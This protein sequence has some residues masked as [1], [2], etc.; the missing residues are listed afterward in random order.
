M[1][2]AEEGIHQFLISASSTKNSCTPAWIDMPLVS[3]TQADG[4]NTQDSRLQV[5]L[6]ELL[7]RI[8]HLFPV[9]SKMEWTLETD[10]SCESLTWMVLP[11]PRPRVQTLSVRTTFS[12]IR[13]PEMKS[14]SRGGMGLRVACFI[15]LSALPSTAEGVLLSRLGVE[16]VAGSPSS[17]LG[18]GLGSRLGDPPPRSRAPFWQRRAEAVVHPLTR[19]ELSSSMSWSC[20]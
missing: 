14:S 9:N 1:V 3:G 17:N 19:R 16:E 8:C 5:P 6:V 13:G 15:P 12:P 4:S 7:S 20:S 2:K 11:S 18:G 10:A